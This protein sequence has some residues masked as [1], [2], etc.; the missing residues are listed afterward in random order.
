MESDSV[1]QIQVLRKVVNGILDFIEK[2]LKQSEVELGKDHYWEVMDA[3]LFAMER[4]TELGAGSL[5]DDLEFLQSSA[6]DKAQH[7]PIMLI[8][9][10]PILR[11]L[12]QAV[13]S[14]TS[15][16]ESSDAE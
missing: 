10:A 13:P 6:N 11:A 3:D 16:S 9:V 8:H 15:P 4:P 1:V 12:S 7:L 2:D 14:Y 5:I